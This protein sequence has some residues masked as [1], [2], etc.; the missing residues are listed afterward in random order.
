MPSRYHY[1]PLT[2]PVWREPV[3]SRLSW[4]PEGNPTPTPVVRART[5]DLVAPFLAA[6]TVAASLAWLPTGQA[7]AQA[8]PVPRGDQ[9]VTVFPLAAPFDA[10][11][12]PQV[13]AVRLTPVERRWP[14]TLVEP[15]LDNVV[16]GVDVTDVRPQAPPVRI[17]QD[18]TVLPPF[19]APTFDARLFPWPGTVP[20]AAAPARPRADLTVVPPFQPPTFDPKQ[21]PVVV[22]SPV[23]PAERRQ[24]STLV[25]PLLDNVVIGVD[26]TDVPPARPLPRAAPAW[27]VVSPLPPVPYD[28]ARM[29]WLPAGAP[30]APRQLPG[31]YTQVVFVGDYGSPPPP[32]TPPPPTEAGP[33]GGKVRKRSPKAPAIRVRGVIRDPLLRLEP[34]QREEAPPAPTAE[35]PRPAEPQPGASS[36]SQ[37]SVPAPAQAA[38]AAPKPKRQRRPKLPPLAPVVPPLDWM[39]VFRTAEPEPPA[40]P[41]V[42][43]EDDFL[44][45]LIMRRAHRLT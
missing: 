11:Q 27:T 21:F 9:S 8:L 38:P 22:L 37:A 42:T 16:V 34:D 20:P 14:S 5:S 36:A 44:T 25:E 23:F 31:P 7:R 24:P 39:P 17:P 33:G 12:F 2:G 29:E 10:S 19:Q 41:V 28:P 26:V 35:G 32:P 13:S 40:P 4:L 18:L 6:L 43:D 1:Q 30:P 45:L 15:L 3:A